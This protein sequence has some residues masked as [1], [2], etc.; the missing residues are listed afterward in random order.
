MTAN[1][2]LR[3]VHVVGVTTPSVEGTVD[4]L[5]EAGTVTAVDRGL[6]APRGTPEVAADGRWLIP[7]LWDQHVHLGEWVRAAQRVDFSATTTPEDVLRTVADRIASRPGETLIGFGHRSGTWGREVTVAE[8]DAVAGD[9]PVVLVSGDVHHGWLGSAALRALG[10]PARDTVLREDEWFAVYARIHELTGGRA[11]TPAAYRA[12]LDAAAALGVVGLVD[13]ELADNTHD[14]PERW[15]LAANGVRIRAASYADALD[16]V[17]ARGLR[18]GDPLPGCAGLATAGP[19]KI[20]SDGSL[21]TRTA[22]C[23]SPYS[24]GDRL[25]HP[26][27][28]PNLAADE[29]TDLMRRAAAHGLAV[30]THAIGDAAVHRAVETYERT[31]ARG[32]I[33]HVQ[34]A[35]IEDLTRMAR[36]GLRA[37]VQ[38]AHLLDDHAVIDDLWPGLGGRCFSLRTMLDSGVDVVLGSDAPVSPLDPWLSMA[39]AV[40]AGTALEGW[41]VEQA[42]TPREALAASVDGQPTVGPGSRGDL[43]LLDADPLRTDLR[44]VGVAAT[45]VAG[46]E[47]FWR[48]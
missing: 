40:R 46:A 14:W 25:D 26:S 10:V 41:H 13:L 12:A 37:S 16:D 30:A 8:L 22:W 5:V 23:C 1:L 42:L 3:D 18:T 4:V 44:R 21:N 11:T 19:L 36:L 45:Y 34:L 2:L 33:E 38:P 15:A 27:G 29:L 39:A 31:G 24:D 48:S 35:A 32:S 20:I 47:V 43:V 6:S 7:G 9:V 17:I 28:R